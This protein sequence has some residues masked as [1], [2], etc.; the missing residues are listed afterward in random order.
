MICPALPSLLKSIV[1]D[2]AWG[3]YVAF[4]ADIDPYR[5]AWV[6]LSRSHSAVWWGLSTAIPLSE[7]VTARTGRVRQT[8]V[9]KLMPST[10][11]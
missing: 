10:E 8:S 3:Y 4:K 9:I 2:A 1:F 11:G 7:A 6:G 5:R